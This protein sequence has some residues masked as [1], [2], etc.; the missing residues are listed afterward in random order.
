M[1]HL[2]SGARGQPG[3][4]G[5]TLSQL[6][7]QKLAIMSVTQE[8]E[9]GETL[10]SRRQ[11]LQGAEITPPFSSLGKKSETPSEKIYLYFYINIYL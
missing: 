5:E 2:R 6:K 11:R 7:I 1:G 10:K 8:T 4:H 3:Q 9:A